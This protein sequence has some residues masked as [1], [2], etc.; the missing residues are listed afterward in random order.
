L[1]GSEDVAGRLEVTLG[2]ALVE[3]VKKVVLVVITLAAASGVA[4][5][6]A[7]DI[8]PDVADVPTEV[9]VAPSESDESP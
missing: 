1:A 6:S 4:G 2:E 9:E 8:G 5:V 3:E 7:I